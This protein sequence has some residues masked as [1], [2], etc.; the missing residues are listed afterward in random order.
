M[1]YYYKKT[2]TYIPASYFPGYSDLRAECDI[3]RNSGSSWGRVMA[4]KI[5]GRA[6]LQKDLN[7]DKDITDLAAPEIRRQ[8]I[9]EIETDFRDDMER[10]RD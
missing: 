10:Y 7:I 3:S 2:Y 1:K 4:L 8:I 5:Y 9:E 6:G